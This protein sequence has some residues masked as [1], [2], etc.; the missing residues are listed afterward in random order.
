MDI[1]QLVCIVC[2]MGCPME[3][4]LNGKCVVEV[5]GN[6]C[7]RGK[8][9]AQAECTNP[10]RVITTT[11]VAENGQ[12]VSVKSSKALPKEKWRT[13]MNR[14]NQTVVKLPVVIG[15]VVIR[16]IEPGIDIIATKDCK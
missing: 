14:I 7:P 5:K 6:S 16:G 3:V 10:T 15:E 1:M 8:A 12:L 9:Y 4:T 11:A 13:Y 2:P